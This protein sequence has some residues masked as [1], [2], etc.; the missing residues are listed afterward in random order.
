M[1]TL[2]NEPLQIIPK[3]KHIFYCRK[4]LPVLFVIAYFVTYL[5][6]QF[7]LLKE[8]KKERKKHRKKEKKKK[9]KKKGRKKEQ[10]G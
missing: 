10:H 6:R 7:I 1:N 3:Q 8:R 2:V 9:R 5:R 4:I